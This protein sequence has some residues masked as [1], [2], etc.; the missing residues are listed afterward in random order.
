MAEIKT[1]RGDIRGYTR[2]CREMQHWTDNVEQ[3]AFLGKKKI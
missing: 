3:V 1:L 2:C